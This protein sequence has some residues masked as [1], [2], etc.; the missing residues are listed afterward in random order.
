MM[1]KYPWKVLKNEFS[2]IKNIFEEDYKSFE[3]P[4]YYKGYSLGDIAA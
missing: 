1:K 3:K 2:D 4:K